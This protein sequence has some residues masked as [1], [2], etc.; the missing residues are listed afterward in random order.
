MMIRNSNETSIQCLDGFSE[1]IR[2][3][4][5][6]TRAAYL[7]NYPYQ[8]TSRADCFFLETSVDVSVPRM[9]MSGN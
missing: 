4:R 6:Q 2:G 1:N 5:Q 7:S 9:I 8:V 3:K